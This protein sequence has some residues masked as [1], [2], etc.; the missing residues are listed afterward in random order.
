MKRIL[1]GVFMICCGA[2][3][4]AQDINFSQFYE[5]P[6]LRNPALS[7]FYRGDIRV[8]SGFRRQWGSVTVPFQ[9]MALGVETKFNVSDRS[10]DYVSIGLQTTNDIAGDSRLGKTQVMPAVTYH[11]TLNGE[12]SYLSL[13]FIG[14]LVQQRFDP[15]RL[16]F[17]DQ[18]VNGSY[19]ATNPTSQ[20]FNNTNLS[21]FDMS[22]GAAYSTSF[23]YESKMYIGA[24]YFHFNKPKVAF[25]REHD[26]SLNPKIV[27]NVGVNTPVSE[28]DQLFFYGDFFYQGGSYQGQGGAL[29]S[30]S[31]VEEE[32]DYK[33]AMGVGLFYRWNDALVPLVKFDYYNLSLGVSYDVNVS[34]LKTASQMKGGFEL[35]LSYRNYL[36]IRSSS[37]RQQRCPV[38]F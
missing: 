13:G 35:T 31:F 25:S 37:S 3:A 29:L 14:G 22:V 16:S 8:T 33:L 20:T 24:A 2:H 28:I 23:G 5:L 12:D 11:K 15:S 17:D 27:F 6:L 1:I 18:F 30:H 26:I 32:E 9:T 19:S 36:N 10:G 4:I 7:G 34:K 38:E 21:Y